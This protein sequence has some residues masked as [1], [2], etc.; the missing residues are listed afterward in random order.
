MKK[1]HKKSAISAD[2]TCLVSDNA[3]SE[4]NGQCA[5][6][7]F[8]PNN[9]SD[10]ALVVNLVAQHQPRAF[11]NFA[12][13]SHVFLVLNVSSG[14][15]YGSLAKVE[16]AFT[17]TYR[18]QLDSPYSASKAASDHHQGLIVAY[19]E[20]NTCSKGLINAEQLKNLAQPLA[21]NVLCG[22][23]YQ[24][25]QPQGRLLRV[26]HGTVFDVAE[27]IRSSSD[28]LGQ[29]TVAELPAE[30]KR[31]LWTR[32]SFAHGFVVLSET[33]ECLYKTTDCWAPEFE[34][35]ITLSDPAIGI[36]W[37]IQGEPCLSAKDKQVKVL[38]NAGHFA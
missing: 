19:P 5:V 18:Y 16:P 37:P 22:L 26:V 35:S 14:A 7:M 9:P 12:A 32:E 27:D 36:Q 34:R 30:N 21:K 38:A 1:Q 24:I 33:A 11:V 17:E 6:A 31:M 13:E 4:T 20:E 15:G 29:Y 2:T 25:Q 8:G 28:N 3:G 23:R 10:S